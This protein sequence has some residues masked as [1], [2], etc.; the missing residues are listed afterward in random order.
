MMS[1]QSVDRSGAPQDEAATTYPEAVHISEQEK[2]NLDQAGNQA[3]QYPG[4]IRLG[5][6]LLSLSLA[7]FLYGLVSQL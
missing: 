5:F 6:I 7:V 1:E 3:P 2:D 4:P